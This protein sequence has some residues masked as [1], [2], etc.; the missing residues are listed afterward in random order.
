MI[1]LINDNCLNVIKN[2][3]VIGHTTLTIT[4]PPYNMN[5]RIRNGK[6]TSRQIV[7]EFSTKYKNFNDNLTMEDYYKFNEE[8]LNYLTQ[9]SN[10]VF[11][12]IQFLTG[13]KRALFKLIGEFNEQ[14]KEVIVW[15]KVNAQPAISKKVLNSQ[16]EL[17]LVFDRINAISRLFENATFDKG[18]L[19]NVWDIK[20]E[21]KINKNHGAVFPEKLVEKIILNFSKP[22]DLVFDPF[23]GTGTVGVVCKK[24]NRHFLGIEL[25]KEYY[26]FAVD[27]INNTQTGLF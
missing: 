13:N 17:L 15:N 27:R 12:N 7:K 16:Y 4:S 6:Y 2:E 22:G 21:K 19:S 24:Y 3:M 1:N 25:D 18:T 5:L 26:D 9:V 14:L 10:L 11:F 8:V 23:M 20:R